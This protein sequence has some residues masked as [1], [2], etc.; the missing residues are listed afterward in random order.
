MHYGVNPRGQGVE[1][2]AAEVGITVGRAY[3]EM[4]W[5]QNSPINGVKRSCVAGVDDADA[6]FPV[7]ARDR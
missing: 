4:Q 3:C 1:G 5:L 6:A 2:D 7:M